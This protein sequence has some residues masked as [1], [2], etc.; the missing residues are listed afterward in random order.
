MKINEIHTPEIEVM[1]D[2]FD[3]RTK[4]HICLVQKYAE[5]IENYFPELSGVVDQAKDHDSSKYENPEYEPYLY[6]TW[7]YRCKD[8]GINFKMPE[9]IDDSLATLHHIKNNRRLSICPSNT[10][11]IQ[12]LT[13]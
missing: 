3:K 2:F 11:Y 6:I 9:D 13:G 5:I 4:N 10:Y 7:H 1:K 12:M 8:N